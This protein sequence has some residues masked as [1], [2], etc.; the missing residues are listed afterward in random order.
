M[1]GLSKSS[2][3]FPHFKKL[4]NK[5]SASSNEYDVQPPALG[6][7]SFCHQSLKGEVAPAPAA[8]VSRSQT[9]VPLLAKCTPMLL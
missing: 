7:S 3:G 6:S 2:T 4:T 1:H 5:R 8:I 9:Q